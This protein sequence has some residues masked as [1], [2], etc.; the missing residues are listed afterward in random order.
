MAQGEHDAGRPSGLDA[1]FAALGICPNC[2]GEGVHLI[3]W[4]DPTVQGELSTRGAKRSA[5]AHIRCVS[6]VWWKRRI[7]QG[8]KY[9]YFGALGLSAAAAAGL[10]GETYAAD[11]TTDTR[12]L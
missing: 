2:Q 10:A 3:G 5:V 11:L 7:G 12:T 1:F 6:S 4:S 8:V 9:G